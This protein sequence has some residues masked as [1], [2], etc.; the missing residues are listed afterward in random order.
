MAL[1]TSLLLLLPPPPP[2]P[3]PPPLLPGA[4]SWRQRRRCPYA[5]SRGAAHREG[6]YKPANSKLALPAACPPSPPPPPSGSR[7]GGA[8]NSKPIPTTQPR[9]FR[10]SLKALMWPWRSS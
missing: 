2:P 4:A 10:S 7:Q 5:A 6:R 9:L 1:L 3:P 8:L